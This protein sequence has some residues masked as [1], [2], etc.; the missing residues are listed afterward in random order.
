MEQRDFVCF[1]ERSSRRRI[2]LLLFD[3]NKIKNQVNLTQDVVRHRLVR[4]INSHHD[5]MKV[6]DQ[7][8][9]CSIYYEIRSMPHATEEDRMAILFGTE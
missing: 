5:D 1:P 9:L 4:W 6:K 3:N 2:G 7:V 8:E